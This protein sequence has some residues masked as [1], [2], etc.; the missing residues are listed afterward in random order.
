MT[1]AKMFARSARDMHRHQQEARRAIATG[2]EKAIAQVGAPGVPKRTGRL[3]LS[4]RT[5]LDAGRI[6]AWRLGQTYKNFSNLHYAGI[7]AFGR[8]RDRRGRMIGSKQNPKGHHV[9][10][11]AKAR[12]A[13]LRFAW[14]PRR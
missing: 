1:P 5:N 8:F 14:R 10:G 11:D 3:G 12:E 13:F 9:T 2:Y 6:G 7:I 4:I